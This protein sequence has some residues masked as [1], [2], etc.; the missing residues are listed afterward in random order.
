MSHKKPAKNVTAD[1]DLAAW[2]AALAAPDVPDVVPPGWKTSTEVA[3][4]LGRSP[5]T[6]LRY[7]SAAVAAGKCEAK[8]FRVPAGLR[9]IYP[10]VHYR[11]T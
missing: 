7:V 5:C 9:G 8:K 1:P 4:M 3:A 10:V 6:A 11:L 2:C